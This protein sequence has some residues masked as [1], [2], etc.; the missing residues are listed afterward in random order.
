MGIVGT[1]CA[2]TITMEYS[3]YC[4]HGVYALDTKP[5]CDSPGGHVM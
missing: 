1:S 3:Q 2:L 5:L 4:D